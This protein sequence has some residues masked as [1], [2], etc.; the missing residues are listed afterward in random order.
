MKRCKICSAKLVSFIDYKKQPS[1]AQHLPNMKMLQSDFDIPL[2]IFECTGCGTVQLVTDPV[3][4]YSQAIRSPDW[5]INPFRKKQRSKFIKEFELENKIIKQINR[6]PKEDSYDAFTMFNYLE[7]FPSPKDTLKQICNNLNDNGVGIVEVPNF[8][9]IIRDRIF[10]EFIIDHLFYF[11][12]KTLRFVCE[13]SGFDVIKIE[14][15]WN[16]ASL[17][18][19]V[20]KRPLLKPI[21][22]RENEI[23]LIGDI[24]NF[25]NQFKSVTFWGAGHQTLMILS[26]MKTIHKVSYIVDDF[27]VKQ[28]LYTPVTHKEILPSNTLLTNPTDAII[29][30]VGWQYKNVL[31]RLRNLNLTQMPKIALIKKATLEIYEDI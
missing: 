3:S 9:E 21:L 11:T 20:K 1:K 30:M 18:A 22:F 19:T 15:I 5:N 23:E 17:S 16:G 13:A 7:H 10:G 29:I 28:F 4:Y 6:E 27:K 14:E 31:K 8:D 26:M 24:D 2:H 12:E 25:A